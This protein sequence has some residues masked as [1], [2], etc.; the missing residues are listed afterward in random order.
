MFYSV[1]RLKTSKIL[2]Y[3]CSICIYIFVRK[4]IFSIF[5]EHFIWFHEKSHV[6]IINSTPLWCCFFIKYTTMQ[7]Y[8]KKGGSWV[9]RIEKKVIF[10]WPFWKSRLTHTYSMWIP[11]K[12][13]FYKLGMKPLI[14]LVVIFIFHYII[15]DMQSGQVKII[16][17]I[18]NVIYLWNINQFLL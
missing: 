5:H 10:L 15:S 18:R 11:F 17:A 12:M 14:H 4:I 8:P 2:Y 9:R 16:T 6:K 7:E 3:L 1:F 13:F